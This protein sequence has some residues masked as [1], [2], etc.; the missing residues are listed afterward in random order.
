M[1][2]AVIHFQTKAWTTRP[3]AGKLPPEAGLQLLAI[4]KLQA[5]SLASMSV[6]GW[7]STVAERT[8]LTRDTRKPTRSN[9]SDPEESY[10]YR[11]LALVERQTLAESSNIRIAAY[12]R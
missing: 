9:I 1:A 12:I 11:N 7:G 6:D 8:Q 10:S 5:L 4:S 3:G 2:D